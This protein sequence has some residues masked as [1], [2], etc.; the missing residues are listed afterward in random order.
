MGVARQTQQ[1]ESDSTA[2]AAAAND[3]GQ[4]KSAYTTSKSLHS[5]QQPLVAV[6]PVVT[7]KIGPSGITTTT[8]SAP[9]IVTAVAS[10]KKG[11]P[12]ASKEAVASM[13]TATAAAQAMPVLVDASATA[14]SKSGMVLPSSS[15]RQAMK[16]TNK[17]SNAWAP[18]AAVICRVPTA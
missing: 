9:T 2:Q 10:A 14:V 12:R 1:G 15:V 18:M 7:I 4:S 5:K 3:G 11:V 8:S 17:W 13:A 16:Y 6:A